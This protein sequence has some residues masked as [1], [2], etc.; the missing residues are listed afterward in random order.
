ML[1]RLFKG[2]VLS[3]GAVVARECGLSCAVAAYGA[4]KL[5]RSGENAYLEGTRGFVQ[6]FDENLDQH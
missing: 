4:T 6:S 2:L 1:T 5:F 3:S